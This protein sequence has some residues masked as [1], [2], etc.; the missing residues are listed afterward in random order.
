[1]LSDQRLRRSRRLSLTRRIA[2]DG[3]TGWRPVA[4][5]MVVRVASAADRRTS[6]PPYQRVISVTETGRRTVGEVTERRRGELARIVGAMPV[7]R[8]HH[9]IDALRTFTG[10]GCEPTVGSGRAVW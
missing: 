2:V 7:G 4:A 10:T 8:W 9:L 6:G 1:M 3:C 5:E